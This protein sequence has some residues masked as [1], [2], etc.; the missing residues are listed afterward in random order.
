MNREQKKAAAAQIEQAYIRAMS[1]SSWAN[2]IQN[3]KQDEAR[4][5]TENLVSLL[6]RHCPL[7]TGVQDGWEADLAE[8]EKVFAR[9]LAA[10]PEVYFSSG[11]GPN[12]AQLQS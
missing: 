2:T 4:T 10:H 7:P 3:S 5:L 6:S 9:L 12:E 8:A 11:L 1:A